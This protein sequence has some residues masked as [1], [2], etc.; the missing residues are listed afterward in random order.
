LSP[1]LGR[2][3]VQDASRSI[4]AVTVDDRCCFA[5]TFHELSDPEVVRHAWA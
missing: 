1:K 4:T 5:D 2:Q 3:L